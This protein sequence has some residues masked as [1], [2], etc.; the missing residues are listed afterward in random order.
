MADLE[1]MDASIWTHYNMLFDKNK[2][3]NVKYCTFLANHDMDTDKYYILF[4]D[5]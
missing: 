3:G 1:F 5:F 2:D 4:G